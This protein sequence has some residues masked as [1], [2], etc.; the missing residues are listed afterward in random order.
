PGI[1]ALVPRRAPAVDEA[2]A[3][4]EME[5]GDR[6]AAARRQLSRCQLGAGPLRLRHR[7]LPP[8]TSTHVGVC[9]AI[10]A[11][12]GAR[13]SLPGSIRREWPSSPTPLPTLGEG[14][15]PS[16]PPA[17]DAGGFSP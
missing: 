12:R 16:W 2:L 1:A 8:R 7:S 11:Q 5:R 6:D 17:L 4:V 14:S 15:D 10:V 13:A 9:E 3:L